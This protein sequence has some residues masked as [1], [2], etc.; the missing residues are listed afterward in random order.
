M[1]HQVLFLEIN[2]YLDQSI[3]FRHNSNL[4]FFF[5]FIFSKPFANNAPMRKHNFTEEAK[6]LNIVSVVILAL[7]YHVFVRW[8]KVVAETPLEFEEKTPKKKKN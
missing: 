1:K 5:F 8:L 6:H 4:F 7:L 2:Q 3:S